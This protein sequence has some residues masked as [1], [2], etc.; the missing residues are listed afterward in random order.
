MA[1][2]WPAG[3]VRPV[4][5]RSGSQVCS[6]D[7][8][9]TRFGTLG[10]AGQSLA[11]MWPRLPLLLGAL[12]GLAAQEQPEE[13]SWPPPELSTRGEVW[14]L[15]QKVDFG[16]ENR[17]IRR[18]A[19]LVAFQ[20]LRDV[21]CDVLDFAKRTYRRPCAGRIV[22]WL[23]RRSGSSRTAVRPRRRAA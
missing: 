8:A 13:E 2:A 12:A 17:T 18:G 11:S 19:V 14:P 16:K 6:T 23:Q 22:S 5:P 9:L 7:R 4:R 10:R 1:W 21:D 15:P 20:G 3:F